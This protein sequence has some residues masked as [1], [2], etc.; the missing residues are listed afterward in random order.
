MNPKNTYMNNL[1]LNKPS[2]AWQNYGSTQT[3][4]RVPGA[5]L[6]KKDI[7]VTPSDT[8]ATGT[9]GTKITSPAGQA[10]VSKISQPTIDGLMA[11]AKS[12]QSQ[13][14]GATS[15]TSSNEAYKNTPEYKAYIK[16]QSDK[17]NPTSSMNAQKNYQA[18]LQR[19]AD[20]QSQREKQEYDAR[21]AEKAIYETGGGL[22]S[23]TR[24]G[25]SAYSRRAT[26]DANDLALQ[27]SAAARAAGVASELYT[28][29]REQE[30]ANA[31]PLTY[32]EAQAL[33]VVYGT[34]VGEA[35][36][37]GKI[38]EAPEAEGFSLSEGQARYDA[39]GNLIAQRGKTYA[40]GTGG[41]GGTASSTGGIIG[42]DG[43]PL[44]LL[45]GQVDTIANYDNTL[46]AATRA[47]ALLDE[48]VST[49][50][51]SNLLLQGKKFAGYGNEKQL[52]MEQLLGKLRADF[53]KAISGAAVSEQEVKRLN[54]F[55]PDLGDQ[56]NVIKSKLNNLLTELASSK[57]TYIKTIGGTSSQP[58][59]SSAQQMQLPNGEIVTLQPD[60]TY[61]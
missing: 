54:K 5:I 50:P 17:E 26:D 8:S 2:Q 38:P 19:L 14:P 25:V 48:G 59:V 57:D 53:M 42:A 58:S 40:P 60:G 22:K 36:A 35:K 15:G 30:I 31:K 41:T 61:Q 27:E 24:E 39:Q 11:Q 29:Y 51:V 44:K 4:N 1:N 43:K 32:E 45:A 33:G 3:L 28:P 6:P 18:S 37:L 7:P 49:G 13:I 16:Y 55:L 56:E 12:I 46:N 9:S 21:K 47:L 20:I 10:Y 23:G 34:T 52:Q